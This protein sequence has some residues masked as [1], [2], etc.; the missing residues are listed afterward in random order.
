MEHVD[1][2]PDDL[3]VEGDTK[4]IYLVLDG[5][6]GIAS[7]G[8]PTALEEANIPNL[9]QL[10]KDHTTGVAD[11]V[12]PG[13]VPGSPSGHLGI[14][15]YDPVA[16][17]VGRGIFTALGIDFSLTKRDVAARLNFCTVNDQDVVV[18]R[19]AGRISTEENRRLCEDVNRQLE[20]PDELE[21][22]LETVS[23]HRALLVLRGNDLSGDLSDSD[24]GR[25]GSPLRTV[26][27]LS[28]DAE[29]TEE[30]VQEVIR[31]IRTILS[32]EEPANMVI[33]RGYDR[34]QHFPSLRE[35]FQ[36]Q[37]LTIAEYPMYRGF[38]KLLGMEA[39]DPEFDHEGEMFERVE[40]D[41]SRKDL[42]Y[43]HVK[44]TD[45][46][47]EDGD[48][49][50]KVNVLERVD[51]HLPKLLDLDPSVLLVTADHSSPAALGSHSWH[52]VPVLLASGTARRD[53][54][55]VFTESEAERGGLGHG[56]GTRLMSL[57][58]AH[59]GRMKKFGA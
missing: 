55:T 51:R 22:F 23:E 40:E 42:F 56:P 24:P 17:Q 48:R 6:G 36:L 53:R 54:S 59:A 38:G 8:E 2:I 10:A 35:R 50:G 30:A 45:S 3:V 31:Q 14:F 1:R 43:I 32:E 34:Y 12:A 20:P 29:R 47:G 58:L 11:P 28:S 19:R 33:S 7:G 16:H 41:W 5:V 37:G 26:K 52:P 25:P 46:Y 49:A 57:A 44:K 39:T 21:V 15:G 9:D 18:D 4:I 13:V 27:A